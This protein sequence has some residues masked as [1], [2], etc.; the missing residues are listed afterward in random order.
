MPR[1]DD[2]EQPRVRLWSW[3][4]CPN[5]AQAHLERVFQCLRCL[6]L[7]R[8]LQRVQTVI[9]R[10]CHHCFDCLEGHCLVATVRLV[11]HSIANQRLSYLPHLRI[12]PAHHGLLTRCR[13]W[14]VRPLSLGAIDHR[15]Q[16]RQ[17][18]DHR[19]RHLGLNPARCLMFAPLMNRRWRP[20]FDLLRHHHQA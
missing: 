7:P 18:P 16:H 13:R 11:L 10:D 8:C 12:H 2:P 19:L 1:V 14:A 15:Q 6:R 3:G 9:R 4:H 17:S 5:P 20:R